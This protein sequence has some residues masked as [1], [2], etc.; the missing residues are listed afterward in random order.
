MQQDTFF[1]QI[2][3][4]LSSVLPQICGF[5]RHGKE[6]PLQKMPLY[7]WVLYGSHPSSQKL[8]ITVTRHGTDASDDIMPH[9]FLEP[10]AANH[11]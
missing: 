11:L 2:S 9:I 6:F 3:W 1:W 4:Q 8:L 5:L 7:F 10:L